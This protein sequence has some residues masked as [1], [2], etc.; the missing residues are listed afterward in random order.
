MKTVKIAMVGQA[1]KE[2]AVED[3]A[4]VNDALVVAELS[5][6]GYDIKMGGATVS[7]DTNVTDNALIILVKKI[8][9]GSDPVTV[10]VAMVGQAVKEVAVDCGSTVGD[11][12]S[13]AGVSAEGYDVKMGGTTV[14]LSDTVSANALIILVKKIKGG[15]A[16]A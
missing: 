10:K 2:V 3:T 1:V 4:T 14:D 8:K 6:E 13:I 12:L 5:S 7:L 15:I 9:G 16:A 11:A